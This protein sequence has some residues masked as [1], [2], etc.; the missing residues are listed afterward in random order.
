MKHKRNT[1]ILLFLCTQ[2]ARNHTWY[3]TYRMLEN[4][5]LV[6]STAFDVFIMFRL[7][8]FFSWPRKHTG[9]KFWSLWLGK[10]TKIM[11]WKSWVHFPFH[12]HSSSRQTHQMWIWQEDLHSPY[13]SFCWFWKGLLILLVFFGAG[14]PYTLSRS[15]RPA[16]FFRDPDTNALEFAQFDA[17]YA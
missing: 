1:K 15:G 6:Y 11:K 14:I 9:T 2:K 8:S 16:I 4:D 10:D 7:R 5:F 13:Y 12:F 17:W 3:E